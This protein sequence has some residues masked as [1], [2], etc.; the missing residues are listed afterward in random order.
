MPWEVR[1][2]PL[3]CFGSGLCD[4]RVATPAGMIWTVL[5]INHAGY[6][7]PDISVEGEGLGAAPTMATGFLIFFDLEDVLE[8][9]SRG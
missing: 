5:D 3:I 2:D 7:Q 1:N 8:R 4:R 6:N 9:R